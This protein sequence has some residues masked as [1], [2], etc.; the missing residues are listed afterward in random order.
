MFSQMLTKLQAGQYD[1]AKVRA[2][3]QRMIDRKVCFPTPCAMNVQDCRLLPCLGVVAA[4]HHVLTVD[5]PFLPRNEG[6]IEQDG[7][8]AHMVR[9]TSP[10][11]RAHTSS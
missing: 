6:D 1:E 10:L 4:V 2:E 9:P 3:V 8:H 7:S 11:A 5:M